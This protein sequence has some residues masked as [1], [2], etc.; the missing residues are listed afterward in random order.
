MAELQTVE[1]DPQAGS[2]TYQLSVWLKDLIPRT[3]GAVRTVVRRELVL[4][5]REFFRETYAWRTTIGPRDIKANKK[6]YRLSPYD[7]YADVIHVFSIEH[8]GIPLKM[9]TRKPPTTTTAEEP[10]S[11]YLSDPDT[12]HF[13]PT[14]TK[15]AEDV[16]TYHVALQPNW[17]TKRVP[18]VGVIE[19][20]DAI[21][22]GAIG[23]LCSQP[24]K[25]YTN[26]VLAQYHLRRFRAAIGEARAKAR[27][28]YTSGQAWQ[29]PP[30]V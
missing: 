22:D 13:Y 25:G 7:A 9:L 21:L 1:I 30:F 18:R 4:T 3:P 20:Y 11:F 16:L 29:F 23:R 12:V 24:A 14:P 10:T 15:A 2:E 17:N 28:G 8:K 19:F 27:A 6:S 5:L 26:P